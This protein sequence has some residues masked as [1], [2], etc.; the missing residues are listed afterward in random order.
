[1]T[2][3]DLK[4]YYYYLIF[5]RHCAC[6]CVMLCSCKNFVQRCI[7]AVICYWVL[8]LVYW[9]QSA[10][11]LCITPVCNGM[12]DHLWVGKPSWHVT[13]DPGQFNLAI[14]SW[15]GT[16][17]TS[18]SSEV[19]GHTIRCTSPVSVVLQRKLMSG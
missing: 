2:G 5:T 9:S 17:S 18:E 1:M 13:G 3:F 7:L 16:V 8:V 10:K 6:F 19:D 12:V 14:P 4:A 11:L 15:V